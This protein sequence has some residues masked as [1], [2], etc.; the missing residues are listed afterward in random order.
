LADGGRWQLARQ[1]C[2]T[3]RKQ[4]D[5]RH[6]V[7]AANFAKTK[8]N[9]NF[10]QGYLGVMTPASSISGQAVRQPFTNSTYDQYIGAFEDLQLA[11]TS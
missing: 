7:L 3:R 2:F 6:R 11:E 5:D 1:L 4:L 8:Q 9:P 10:T